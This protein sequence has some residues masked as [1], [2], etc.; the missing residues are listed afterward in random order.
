MTRFSQT[1][2]F[3]MTVRS[4]KTA[5]V[6]CG[7][8]LGWL[9]GA[10]Q[11][12]AYSE[13]FE[14]SGSGWPEETFDPPCNYMRYEDGRYRM[15]KCDDSQTVRATPGV[16]APADFVLEADIGFLNT[17]YNTS[18][19]I[20][21]GGDG[22]LAEFYK[23]S[24]VQRPGECPDP[25][26]CIVYQEI[27]FSRTSWDDILDQGVTVSLLQ[28]PIWTADALN[29]WTEPNHWR[30]VRRAGYIH[31]FRNGLRLH[32]VYDVDLAGERTFGFGV[33]RYE[34]FTAE[35]VFDDLSVVETEP[36]SCFTAVECAVG[37]WCNGGQCAAYEPCAQGA[38]PSGSFCVKALDRCVEERS[39]DC[40]V[41]TEP[42]NPAPEEPFSVIVEPDVAYGH[43]SLEV[44]DLFH[45]EDH[46]AASMEQAPDGTRTYTFDGL[47]QNVYGA[48]YVIDEQAARV[49]GRTHFVVGSQPDPTDADGGV[50]PPVDGGRDG[51]ADGD[52]GQADGSVSETK[53][54]G[55]SGCGCRTAAAAQLRA[56]DRDAFWFEMIWM[57]MIW[58]MLIFWG[59]GRR[60]CHRRRRHSS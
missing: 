57:G 51:E 54:G 30:I 22:A 6:G 60:R 23:L 8:I 35:A 34:Y 58:A 26:N 56:T 25:P 50:S 59:Y 55:T 42:Q 19:E 12:W 40:L 1:V 3:S 44:F 38:C 43:A 13:D 33:G 2:R 17:E 10:A 15:S 41:R 4:L 16:L 14:D 7:L 24:N 48:V 32:R 21:F 46:A 37:E 27:R 52:A 11:G 5:A 18:Y 45:M 20:Y 28:E 49:C 53:K 29:M 47:A 36:G 39:G 31:I 9:F